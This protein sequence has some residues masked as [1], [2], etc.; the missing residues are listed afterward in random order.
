MSRLA[1][2]SVST[3]CDDAQICFKSDDASFYLR[4][5]ADRWI[6]DEVDER[7]QRHDDAAN[8]STFDL[9]EKYLIWN[10]ASLAR[11]IIGV[12]RLGAALYAQGFDPEV[13]VHELREGIYR[14]TSAFGDAVVM[15]VPATIFSHLMSK[16][17]EEI[18]RTVRQDLT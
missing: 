10:W 3:D 11:S 17:V 14:L 7:G 12:P 1:N 18:E 15:G 6:L 5:V 4:Q 2:A 9:A 8:F 13:Q 16:S